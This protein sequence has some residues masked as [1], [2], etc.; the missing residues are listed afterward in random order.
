LDGPALCHLQAQRFNFRLRLCHRDSLTTSSSTSPTTDKSV[1]PTR[2]DAPHCTAKTSISTPL[3][4]LVRLVL[5]CLCH[6]H[7]VQQAGNGEVV[8]K[9]TPVTPRANH[10]AGFGAYWLSNS[11]R[12]KSH[13]VHSAGLLMALPSKWRRNMTPSADGGLGVGDIAPRRKWT[14]GLVAL[15][16]RPAL[17]SRCV[18]SP[19]AGADM[20][21]HKATR[22]WAPPAGQPPAGPPLPHWQRRWLVL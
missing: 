3:P 14:S 9:R 13:R 1:H 15:P 22:P 10:V 19:C 20:R 4:Y 16:G 21:S 7:N 6:I 5:R 17:P 2:R 11:L 12:S 8:L 18:G